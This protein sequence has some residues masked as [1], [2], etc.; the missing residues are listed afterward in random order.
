MLQLYNVVIS[1]QD[2]ACTRVEFAICIIAA[3][4]ISLLYHKP[5]RAPRREMLVL[6]KNNLKDNC[7]DNF[8]SKINVSGNKIVKGS[9][10]MLQLRSNI[11][12]K[13]IMS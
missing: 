10:V 8:V 6:L 2:M 13:I 12:L 5:G 4:K 1:I 3:Q 9:S 7:K 11:Y